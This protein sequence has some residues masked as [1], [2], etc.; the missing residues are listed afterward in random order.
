LQK[1]GCHHELAATMLSLHPCV[2]A[3][4]GVLLQPATYIQSM[5]LKG[6]LDSYKT[7]QGWPLTDGKKLQKLIFMGNMQ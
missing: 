3:S 1:A 7:D 6:K 2:H 4:N 5:A